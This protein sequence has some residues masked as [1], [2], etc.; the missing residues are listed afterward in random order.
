MATSPAI[1]AVLADVGPRL[2]QARA[3]RDVTLTA[4]RRRDRDLQEHAVAPRVGPAQ[5]E[6]RAAAADRPGPPDPARRARRRARRRRPAHPPAAPEA[7]RSRGGPAHAAAARHA[8]VEGDHPAGARQPRAAHAR[9]L[10]VA[11]RARGRAPPHRRRPRHHDDGRARSPS[12]TPRSR[13]G[14]APRATGRSRSSASSAGRA[15]GSTSAPRLGARD[16][17]G[18]DR[19]R[20]P[21]A[22]DE[23]PRAPPPGCAR[24]AGAPPRAA[25]PARPP[26]ADPR[27]GAG[28]L[29][30]DHAPRRVAHGRVRPRGRGR[31]G[32]A[33][34]ARQRPGAVLVLRRGRAP[35]RRARGRGRR[36]CR[37][38]SRPRL[39]PTR[40]I[41]TLL[42]ELHAVTRDLVVVLD[43]YHVIES[44]E[45]Q[46]AMAFFLEHLPP[47]I[48][49]VVAQPGRP[50]V[51]TRHASGPAATCSRSAPPTCGSPRRRPPRTSTTPWASPSPPTDVDAIEDR[52]EGWIAA[53][54]LAALSMQ[55]R[56]DVVRL[57]RELRR[58]RP[59]HRRLPRR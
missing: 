9:G 19:R 2:K 31:L 7:Q 18:H 35:H 30:Q 10:R 58:R 57:H 43:D 34:P 23:V 52:T 27:V 20:G 59:L 28:R 17:R 46:D 4:A 39:P 42:N 3:R 11:V 29:R 22:R 15:S 40:S 53:L 41:T 55:G 6:P 5:A 49:L 37:C 36:R 45:I 54:Q 48:R 44:P 32:S 12:S 8:R 24:R 50:A 14:S 25:A 33:R 26:R 1:T 21:A 56:D 47:R 38:C 16:R 51:A 13:T